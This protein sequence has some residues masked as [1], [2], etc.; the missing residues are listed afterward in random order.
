MS[1]C[2]VDDIEGIRASGLVIVTR[3]SVRDAD[4]IGDIRADAWNSSA[5][6]R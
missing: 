1:R 5:S 3:L 2:P 4:P 6:P